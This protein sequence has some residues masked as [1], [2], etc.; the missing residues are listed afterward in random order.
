MADRDI[1]MTNAPCGIRGAV[2]VPQPCR[3]G[4]TI[5]T[6]AF[7]PPTPLI[8]TVAA[9]SPA[10]SPKKRDIASEAYTEAL[11]YLHREFEGNAKASVWLGKATTTSLSDLLDIAKQAESKYSQVSQ[12]KQKTLRSWIRGLSKRITEYGKVLDFLSQH[13]P[14]YVSLVWGV[15]KFVLIGIIN[16]ENL[17]GRFSKALYFIGQALPRC[18]LS[19][20][21][22]ATD[23]MRDAVATLYAHILL[24]LQQAV[25][26][27]NV[28][29]AGRALTSLFKPFE[30]SYKETLDEI[31]LCA[32]TIDDMSS[33]ASKVEIREIK[34]LLQ[35]ETARQAER[36]D[37]LHEM[38][39]KF[40]HAQEELTA[41]VGAVLRIVSC[42]CPQA[43]GNETTLTANSRHR[44]TQ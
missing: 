35:K 18:E 8:Q 10:P 6:P 40:S 19:A 7:G 12:G 11:R 25:K 1:T 14:E 27:Y 9:P 2:R 39:M 43:K 33:L 38:Q 15:V 4:R 41:A 36:E 5:N 31:T 30:L 34:V 26:W 28:G 13:H 16:H 3:P 32:K 20:E 37:K 17:V 23:E 42:E 29:P 44:Q 22:Y 21:L 24:F